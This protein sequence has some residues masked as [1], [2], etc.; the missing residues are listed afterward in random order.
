MAAHPDFQ[1]I[2]L[3]RENNVYGDIKIVCLNEIPNF[4][5]KHL[6]MLNENCEPDVALKKF[7]IYFN[8][9]LQKRKIYW[10]KEKDSFRVNEFNITINDGWVPKN[11]HF[12]MR[13]PNIVT[14][15]SDM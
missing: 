3:V 13:A 9:Q 1:K 7:G 15:R 6:N 12:K 14:H 5:R 11:P 10:N 4:A 2:I 8:D